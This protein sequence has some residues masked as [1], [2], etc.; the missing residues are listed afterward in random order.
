[1]TFDERMSVTGGRIGPWWVA[2]GW[3]RFITPTTDEVRFHHKLGYTSVDFGYMLSINAHRHAKYLWL[4]I[5]HLQHKT[6]KQH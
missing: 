3:H 5:L 1:M 4:S 2:T 6:V